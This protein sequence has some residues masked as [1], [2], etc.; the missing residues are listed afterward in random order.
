MRSAES[1]ETKAY[2][3]YGGQDYAENYHRAGFTVPLL[4]GLL[5]ARGME[6][7]EVKRHEGTNLLILARRRA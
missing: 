1:D 6:I 5:E 4:R 3:V 2:R 7:L